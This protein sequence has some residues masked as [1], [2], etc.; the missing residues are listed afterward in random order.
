MGLTKNKKWKQT[1]RVFSETKQVPIV[2][3]SY[4]HLNAKTQGTWK[5]NGS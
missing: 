4:I 5:A 1:Q 3:I 2:S